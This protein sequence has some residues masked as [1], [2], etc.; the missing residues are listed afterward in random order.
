MDRTERLLGVGYLPSQLPP[1]F[2]TSDLAAKHGQLYADWEKVRLILEAKARGSK[3]P[4]T[5]G[6]K[7]PTGKAE[8]FS[9][10]RVGHQRRTTSIPNP[11]TQTYLA[12]HVVAHWGQL[13]GHY[14]KSRLSVSRPRFLANGSRAA[15][16]PSMHFLYDLKI[17]KSAGY[18]FMLRTDISR[19]FPTIYT[20]SVPWALHTKSIAKRNHQPFGKYYGNLLDLALRQGQDNQ[21]IGLPIGPDTSHIIAEAIATS[22]DVD[23]KKRL[24]V[25]PAGF[26]YVDDYFLFFSTVK[27]AESALAALVRALGEYELQINFE[28]TLTCSVIE[29]TDDYWT[30]KLRNFSID[31]KWRKQSSDINHF[32]ELAKELAR[33]NSDENVMTYAVKR[34]SSEIIRKECWDSFE[35]H[36]S[37]IAMS[38]PNTLQTIA[39]VLST[40][41]GVGYSLNS[42]RLERLVNSVIEDH[43]PLGHHSEVIWC[44]WM[45]KELDIKL[46]DANVDL[47]AEMHGS[48]CALL[49]L[50]LHSKQKLG[51]IPKGSTWK[52]AENSDA[53]HGEQ[54]LLSYEAGMR[55][56]AGF[57]DAHI[58][59]NQYFSILHSLGIHFYDDSASL[60]PL[61]HLKAKTLL[62][63]PQTSLFEF[64]ADEDIDIEDLI[65]FD[66]S[67]GGYEGVIFEYED[68]EQEDEEEEQ[69]KRD[70]SSNETADDDLPW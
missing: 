67:D 30:H 28:K 6:P 60:R 43:A 13:I 26:R 61:F 31:K 65:E 38:Y 69:E 34:I 41:H 16:I 4:K 2:K 45:C 21:T 12:T 40:Y 3:P 15:N 32:F 54:W 17:L 37:H 42:K 22:I 47:V 29:I 23:L 11:V 20:H 18:R 27:E 64:L 46:S 53:L 56:W 9:V 7:A 36:L 62:Q 39:R 24:K 55:G 5:T 8:I 25:L 58:K 10:A 51:K 35:A 1:V 50:D 33:Q 52:Q 68:E 19:F 48:V 59:A 70:K 63:H 49:L 57:S 44:L 66:E 14:R